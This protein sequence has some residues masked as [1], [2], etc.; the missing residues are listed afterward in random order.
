MDSNLNIVTLT[1]DCKNV[2]VIL[3]P[4]VNKV[5][6]AKTKND[7]TVMIE[8]RLRLSKDSCGKGAYEVHYELEMEVDKLYMMDMTEK[9][10]MQVHKQTIFKMQDILVTSFLTMSFLLSTFRD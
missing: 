10:P 7:I 9:K 8:K 3:T 1:A 6:G 5:T 2:G 4:S